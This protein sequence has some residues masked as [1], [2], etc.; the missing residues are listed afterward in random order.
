MKE[1]TYD[2][3]ERLLEYSVKIIKNDILEETEGLNKIFVTS[4]QKNEKKHK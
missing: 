3:K 4:I 1:L 2:L